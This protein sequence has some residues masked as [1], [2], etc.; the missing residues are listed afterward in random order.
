MRLRNLILAVALTALFAL[1]TFAAKR[2]ITGTV[3]CD[4]KG[5]A[6]VV[7]SDG[8][9]VVKTNA[10][11]IYS[12]STDLSLPQAQFV[13][14]SIPSGYE[15]ERKGNRPQFYGVINREAKG[16][17]KFDF[18]LKKVDQTTYTMLAIADSHVCDGVNSAGRADDRKQYC[19]EVVPM[20]NKCAAAHKHPVYMCALGDMSQPRPRRLAREGQKGYTLNNYMEDTKV[21][22]P[23]F[24]VIG[25]H[26]HNGAPKGTMFNE[27]TVYQS[28]KDFNDDLGP[29]YYSFN[30]GREHYVVIDNTFV[31]TRDAGPTSDPKA[32]KGYWM[33]MCEYQHKWLA[34]DM[35]AVDPQ[36]VDRVVILAHCAIF[37]YD[38]KKH[39]MDLERMLNNFKGYEVLALIGHHHADHSIRKMWNGKPLYQFMHTSA[40]GT[41]W[42]SLLNSEGTPAS[43]VDYTF[44]DGKFTRTYFPYGE[45]KDVKYRVYDNRNHKYRHKIS[46]R[47]GTKNSY[48]AELSEASHKDKGAILVNIWNAYTCEFTEST[49]GKG[50]VT[51]KGYDPYFRD[52]YW[53]TLDKSFNEELP[54]GY[55]LKRSGWQRPKKGYHIWQYVPADQKADVR[56]V[57]K[58]AMGNVVA[59]FT[60]NAK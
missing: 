5:V 56:V 33:R 55:R 6:G 25:N 60:A 46:P 22:F 18:R 19:N 29:A 30:I 36:K 37:G 43:V 40:A 26:D 8:F 3:T 1:P 47:T 10:K 28:R 54:V 48:A 39:Q 32:T 58:D 20:L 13:H 16:V 42:H 44:K 34:A 12:F 23:I 41:T 31:I 24:N 7:V 15:V 27:E 52:W 38:G 51:Q 50:K 9:T 45:F 35:A 2:T 59:E 49:G 57:A 53:D 14:I 21:D 17:Q 11:G 4:G